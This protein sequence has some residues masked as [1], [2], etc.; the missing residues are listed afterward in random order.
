MLSNTY[1]TATAS[2]PLVDAV[3]RDA[4]TAITRRTLYGSKY[5]HIN[6]NTRFIAIPS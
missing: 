2:A 1:F 6:L 3:I 4:A 5:G